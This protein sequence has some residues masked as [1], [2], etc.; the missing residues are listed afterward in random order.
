MLTVA[1]PD[2]RV[3]S[4]KRDKEFDSW[5]IWCRKYVMLGCEYYL[6]VCPDKNLKDEV[7]EFIC[8]CADYIIEHIGPVKKE[9]TSAT[10]SWFGLNSSSAL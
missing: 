2:G 3:S 8:R 10:R 4:Y 9:I 5:D 1:E 7:T 6:N